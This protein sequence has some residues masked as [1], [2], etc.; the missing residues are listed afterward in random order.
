MPDKLP[1]TRRLALLLRGKRGALSVSM[2]DLPA[3]P[4]V[5]QHTL[6]SCRSGVGDAFMNLVEVVRD[7]SATSSPRVC[8]VS[9]AALV[10]F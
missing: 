4:T 1:G 7:Y 2:C 10:P 9:A 8:N 6:F 3:V 5:E